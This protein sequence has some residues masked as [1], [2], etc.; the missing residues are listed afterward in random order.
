MI[1]AAS[2]A[3]IRPRRTGAT[4]RSSRRYRGSAPKNWKNRLQKPATNRNKSMRRPFFTTARKSPR[5]WPRLREAFPP[6]RGGSR[7]AEAAT[8]SAIRLAP[9]ERTNAFSTPNSSRTRAPAMG[10]T[11]PPMFTSV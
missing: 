5:N 1:A 10:P 11:N 9:A 4:S 6:S 7:K 3:G 8:R 2:R